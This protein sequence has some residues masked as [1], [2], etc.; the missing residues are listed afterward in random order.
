MLPERPETE[1]MIRENDDEANEYA[2]RGAILPRG[3]TPECYGYDGLG[4]IQEEVLYRDPEHQPEHE[5]EGVG[6]DDGEERGR[7][8]GALEDVG[9]GGKGGEGGEGGAGLGRHEGEG[10]EE[11]LNDGEDG[12]G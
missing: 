12:R 8:A 9:E 6:E 1:E 10:S 3:G 11:E 5:Y 4:E 7:A 2:V